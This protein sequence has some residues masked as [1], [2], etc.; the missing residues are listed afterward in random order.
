M[1]FL[2]CIRCEL[3]HEDVGVSSSFACMYLLHPLCFLFFFDRHFFLY[4]IRFYLMNIH[5]T[6]S[7]ILKWF[8]VSFFHLQEKI[9]SS[10]LCILDPFISTFHHI[11]F[12]VFHIH[13]SHYMQYVLYILLNTL[14]SIRNLCMNISFS[15]SRNFLLLVIFSLFFWFN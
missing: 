2:D 1:C 12:Q 7:F 8:F 9:F 4:S 3:F 14:I 10:F 13:E 11:L 6:F 5:V 15:W